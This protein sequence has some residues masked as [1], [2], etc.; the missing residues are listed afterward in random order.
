VLPGRRDEDRQGD[1]FSLGSA[2]KL[3]FVNT[4][5]DRGAA[6]LEHLRGVEAASGSHGGSPVVIQTVIASS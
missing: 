3:C 4:R 6:T 2:E 1:P 5:D